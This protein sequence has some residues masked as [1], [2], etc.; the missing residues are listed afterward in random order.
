[1]KP[2]PIRFKDQTIDKIKQA[3]EF[4]HHDISN[5]D[6]ARAAMNIG[7]EFLEASKESMTYDEYMIFILNNQ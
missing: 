1:M 5:S 3:T 7:L 4:G 6:A 2:L